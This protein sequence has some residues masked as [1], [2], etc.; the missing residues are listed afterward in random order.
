NESYDE[1][2]VDKKNTRKQDKL[3][4][5]I[6]E[7]I[8]DCSIFLQ[9]GEMLGIYALG[10]IIGPAASFSGSLFI[11]FQNMFCLKMEREDFISHKA[12]EGKEKD[13]IKSN[14]RLTTL[15][16]EIKNLDLIKLTKSIISVALSIFM[17]VEFVFAMSILSP[18]ILLLL[19]TSTTI[20]A[21]WT[22]FYQESMTYPYKC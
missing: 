8:A 12:L 15:F 14:K 3:T 10:T 4:K 1:Y 21:I 16:Y 2:S 17:L 22:H 7:T 6:V 5:R 20:S 13:N 18:T 11:L 19:S 9:L